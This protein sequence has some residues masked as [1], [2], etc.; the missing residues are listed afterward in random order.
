M[1]DE[2]LIVVLL[3]IDLLNASILHKNEIALKQCTYP[4]KGSMEIVSDTSNINRD[5]FQAYTHLVGNKLQFAMYNA[6]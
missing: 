4:K 1:A 5:V 2:H 3:Q 6:Y